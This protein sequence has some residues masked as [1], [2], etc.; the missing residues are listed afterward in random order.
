MFTRLRWCNNKETMTK[1]KHMIHHITR[2]LFTS[3]AWKWIAYFPKP[4]EFNRL[5]TV[6]GRWS[7]T[8]PDIKILR[9][10]HKLLSIFKYLFSFLLIPS[11]KGNSTTITTIAVKWLNYERRHKVWR[12]TTNSVLF[13]KQSRRNWHGNKQFGSFQKHSNDSNPLYFKYQEHGCNQCLD[14]SYMLQ[15]TG[16]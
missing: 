15:K 2:V 1:P 3:S 4:R 16:E 14:T 10:L 8:T 6:T 11:V 5:T 12:I 7:C 13:D 9:S